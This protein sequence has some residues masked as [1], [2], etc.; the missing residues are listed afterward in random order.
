[1]SLYVSPLKRAYLFSSSFVS[2]YNTVQFKVIVD[3]LVLVSAVEWEWYE[4]V[5]RFQ[6]SV[7]DFLRNRVFWNFDFLGDVHMFIIVLKANNKTKNIRDKF[8]MDSIKHT[9]FFNPNPF[10]GQSY[11]RSPLV[12]SRIISWRSGAQGCA[13]F[14]LCHVLLG[15]LPQLCSGVFPEGCQKLYIMMEDVMNLFGFL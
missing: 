1:M 14:Q 9:S 4:V 12:S 3:P 7:R 10:I 13:G 2:K 6:V 15:G 8:H 11:T 5:V